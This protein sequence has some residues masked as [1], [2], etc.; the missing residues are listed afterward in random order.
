[1]TGWDLAA[2]SERGAKE[3]EEKAPSNNCV[4]SIV[5]FLREALTYRFTSYRGVNA[6]CH[7]HWSGSRID[8]AYVGR[9]WVLSRHH[10]TRFFSSSCSSRRRILGTSTRRGTRGWTLVSGL[11]DFHLL[12]LV[13]FVSGYSI[14]WHDS[15]CVAKP[16]LP[17]LKSPCSIRETLVLLNWD[18]VSFCCLLY[19]SKYISYNT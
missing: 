11:I 12:Y 13:F 5:I 7:C 1:M 14:G 15:P 17:F 9:R 6:D 2:A 18:Q 4:H 19:V 8:V 3:E 16:C 10:A